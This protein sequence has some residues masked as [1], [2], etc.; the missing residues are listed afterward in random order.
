MTATKTRSSK[1]PENGAVTNDNSIA[2]NEV[3]TLLEAAAYLRIADAD[4][5]HMVEQQGLPGRLIGQEWRFL[6]SAL[7]DW[8]R[9]PLPRPSKEAVISRIGSWQDDPHLERELEEI[10]KARGRPSSEGG[11]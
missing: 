4:V 8:L 5:I 1:R 11:K 9:T 7:Q 2:S 6:K 3:L 10:H